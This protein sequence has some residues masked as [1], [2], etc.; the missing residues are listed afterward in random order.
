MDHLDLL[1]VG[2]GMA[3]LTA[4]AK[5]ARDGLRVTVIEIG[6]DVGGSARFAGYAWTA[7]TREVMD[8]VNPDAVPALRHKLVDEFDAGVEFIRSVGV[9]AMPAQRILSFG[10][11][12]GFDTNQYLDTCRRLVTETGGE[13]LLR[14]RTHELLTEDG[15]VVG[16]VVEGPD[17]ERRALRATSTLLATGGFQ[18]DKD[19]VREHVG[20]QGDRMQLRS[21]PHSAGAG[22]RLATA[23]GAATGGE[24]AGFYGHLV[25][26]GV[27]FADPSDFVDLSLY[28]SEHALLFN[29]RNE[30]FTDE[31]RGDHLTTMELLDQPE[32][33]GLLIADARVHRDWIVA[34][35]VEGA[36]SL[37]KYAVANRRGG[38][39]GLADSLEE[40]EYLPEEWGYD[41][42]AVAR[43]VAEYNEKAKVGSHSPGRELDPA[44]LDE[45]PWYVIEC[46]PAITF[47]LHGVLIDTQA[48]AL[49]ADGTPVPG[50]LC[51]GS[52]SGGVYQRGY[53]GG[54]ANALVFGLQAAATAA[55]ASS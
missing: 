24:N 15:H 9:E 36:V 35:Y 25:P 31:T 55:D 54:L 12:H 45:G 3:G 46:E 40:L 28:Y 33:R 19:L 53:A 11:G 14:T 23:A 1:V 5:A 17:G 37:D 34:S 26:T 8:E 52:D 22:Y 30:R 18:A 7:P 10:R 21:N 44:P 41:G 27:P 20:T 13:V 48:R 29:L 16:A 39:C 51:A 50:L 47:P 6:E 42:A 2:A 49:K 4:A 32:A 43:A 38:R